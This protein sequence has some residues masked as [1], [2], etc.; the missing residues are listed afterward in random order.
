MEVSLLSHFTNSLLVVQ[1]IQWLKGTARY[2]QFAQWMPIAEGKVHV[3]MSMIGA[4]A[5]GLGMH[6][7]A[8]GNAGIGW[9]LTVVIP[10]LWVVL[11]AAWDWAQ[12][13]TMNQ[14]TFAV[15]AQQKAA[16]PVVTIP[17]PA[18]APKATVTVPAE[19]VVVDH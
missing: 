12:Q 19:N 8:E 15:I 11:H 17:A 1:I 2:R 10:P 9:H 14:L 3:L 6:G 7:A 4:A 5:S 18:L 16:A 13:L